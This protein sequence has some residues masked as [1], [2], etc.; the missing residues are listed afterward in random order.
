MT[1]LSS[2]TVSHN[3]LGHDKFLP[4]QTEETVKLSAYSVRHMATTACQPYRT[5]IHLGRNAC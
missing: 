1:A 4:D 2:I 5:F 3:S